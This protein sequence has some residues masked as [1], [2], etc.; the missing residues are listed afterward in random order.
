MRVSEVSTAVPYKSCLQAL[1]WS[2][3]DKLQGT[4]VEI[5]LELKA[6]VDWTKY[7]RRREEKFD[8]FGTK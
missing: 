6:S 2:A 5:D 1:T 3:T 8:C 4:L 7:V